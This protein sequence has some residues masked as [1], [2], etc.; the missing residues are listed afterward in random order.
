MNPEHPN[1]FL[2]EIARAQMTR[3]IFPLSPIKFMPP[4]RYKC[5]DI[6]YSHLMDAMFNFVG[7]LTGQTIQLLGM[8]TEAMHT[9]LLQ[10][11][12]ISIKNAKYIFN[13]AKDLGQ[14]IVFKPGGMIE[15]WAEKVL[16]DTLNHLGMVHSK[17][18]FQ[19][20]EERAFADVKRTENGGK[21]LDGVI[22][23]GPGY[24]NPFFDLL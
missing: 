16:D 22:R 20:I 10:D 23:R 21:G 19:A 11:R 9:P 2:L 18:M 4:T 3:D 24:L 1:V 12:W 14:E 17:G 7:V 6:F 15:K 13:G 8:M 5:G